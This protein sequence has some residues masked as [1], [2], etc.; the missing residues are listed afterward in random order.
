MYSRSQVIE[1]LQTFL[2]NQKEIIAVFEGGSA[3]TG[4]VDEVSDLDISI[5]CEDNAVELVFQRLGAHLDQLFGILHHYRTPEPAW[6]GFSQ[7]FYQIKQVPPLFYL[8]VAVIKRTIKDKLMEKDRHGTAPIWFQKEPIYD[9]TPS[10]PEV[11]LQRGMKFFLMATQV[12]F[13]LI[14][15]IQKSIV[16]HQWIQAFSNYYGFIARNIAILLNLTYRPE[17]VDFGLRYAAR[18]YPLDQVQLIEK[19][20]KVSSIEELDTMFIQLLER[21]ETLKKEL[22]P[23]W[24]TKE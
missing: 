15:E 7:T 13:L 4:F 16:R 24:G 14:L 22:A 18:D 20:L 1:E 2:F 17:K 5:V 21:Y 23:K 8:D 3:A 6:H 10:T 12:D 19:A 9:N 11:V